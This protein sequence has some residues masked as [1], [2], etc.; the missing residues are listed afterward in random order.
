MSFHPFT[1]YKPSALSLHLHF[2]TP[3]CFSS[4]RTQAQP[5]AEQEFALTVRALL[6]VCSGISNWAIHS[7]VPHEYLPER[8]HF[9]GLKDITVSSPQFKLLEALPHALVKTGRVLTETTHRDS[10]SPLSD[11]HTWVSPLPIS[12]HSPENTVHHTNKKTVLFFIWCN[13]RRMVWNRTNL[14]VFR[15]SKAGAASFF[16]IFSTVPVLHKPCT[17]PFRI[18]KRSKKGI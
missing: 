13:P 2:P 7:W 4:G 11:S 6:Y 18:K 12:K 5:S 1:R 14:T 16:P 3:G 17:L 10:V 15:Q 9:P 8:P